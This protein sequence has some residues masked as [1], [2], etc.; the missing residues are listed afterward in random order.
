MDRSKRARIME[1]LGESRRLFYSPRI[2][3][4]A[5]AEIESRVQE[6]YHDIASEISTDDPCVIARVIQ[7]LMNSESARQAFFRNPDADVFCE[8]LPAFACKI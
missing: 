2:G 5:M 8:N 7:E 3:P 1:N 6:L 4:G